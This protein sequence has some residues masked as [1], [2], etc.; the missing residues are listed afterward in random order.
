MKISLVSEQKEYAVTAQDIVRLFFPSADI[1]IQMD[2]DNDIGLFL[3]TA[4]EGNKIIGTAVIKTG[5]IQ[6]KEKA[7]SE[8]T[9]I[10]GD[11]NN[12]LKRLV[13][14]A[15]FR[16]LSR[17][18]DN[19]PGPWG[20]LTGT[21]PAKIVHRLIDLGWDQNRIR[22][23]L[24]LNYDMSPAK[25][26]LLLKITDIQRPFLL[27]E[28]EARQRVG[29]YIGIPFCPTRCSYCSF[30][31]YSL[32][33]HGHML[34]MF[35]AALHKEIAAIGDYLKSLGR[36]VQ[37]VYIGGGTPTVL[38]SNQLCLL[39]EKINR[40]LISD[41]TREITL[42]AGR[43]DTIT[44]DKLSIARENGITRLSI[45]PQSMNA[46]TLKAIGRFHSPQQVIEAVEM[47][48]KI[49]FKT[50]NMDIILGLPGE[51]VSDLLNTLNQINILKPENLTVHTLAVKRASQLKEEKDRSKLPSNEDSKDDR[52]CIC[53]SCCNGH[54]SILFI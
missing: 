43:P 36:Q 3:S 23:Y 20:I 25:A 27:S 48:K 35:I 38:D 4:L 31:A 1:C 33:K 37:T 18:T 52:N 12:Q 26:E 42:E 10:Q 29:V 51:K 14:V 21:R 49:G 2:E 15:L 30:P 50:L 53:S 34:E 45:N 46:D 13:K 40:H 17:Y 22:E 7:T 47:A 11:E 28:Y 44:Y 16:L 24:I 32:E 19:S 6:M 41:S 39:L 9:P 54:V 5:S 8:E